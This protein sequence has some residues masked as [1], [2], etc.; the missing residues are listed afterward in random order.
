MRGLFA[1]PLLFCGLALLLP[2]WSGSFMC[3]YPGEWFG[4]SFSFSLSYSRT[5]SALLS[6]H[7]EHS[8]L[9]KVGKARL[10]R[11]S[12]Q[13]NS[14]SLYYIQPLRSLNWRNCYFEQIPLVPI[15]WRLFLGQMERNL[16]LL[17]ASIRFSRVQV[18]RLSLP[19]F[20]L[21]HWILAAIQSCCCCYCCCCHRCC[22]FALR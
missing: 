17:F 11:S 1:C 22:C 8:L 10:K 3:I 2:R 19:A 14:L 20:Y 4:F 9:L 5:I 15:V 21:F 16:L 13:L 7:E 18:L 12:N 6:L